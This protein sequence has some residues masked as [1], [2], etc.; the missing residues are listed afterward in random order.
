MK[1]RQ[2]MR[3]MLASDKSWLASKSW[4]TSRTS[5]TLWGT[6]GYHISYKSYSSSST[7]YSSA[8]SKLWNRTLHYT[9][10]TGCSDAVFYPM[11]V[12]FRG[13]RNQLKKLSFLDLYTPRG[14]EDSIEDY[15][16]VFNGSYKFISTTKY[17]H[18]ASKFA[19]SGGE[20]IVT[21]PPKI[22][23]NVTESIEKIKSQRQ[24]WIPEDP[25]KDWDITKECEISGVAPEG[26]KSVIDYSDVFMV[27]GVF[28]SVAGIPVYHGPI[29]VN[30]DYKPSRFTIQ[31]PSLNS[32]EFKL[33]QKVTKETLIDFK[34]A[35]QLKE[36]LEEMEKRYLKAREGF[37]T[38]SVVKITTMEQAEFILDNFELTFIDEETASKL[39]AEEKKLRKAGFTVHSFFSHGEKARTQVKDISELYSEFTP[40]V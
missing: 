8:S 29:Y 13:V 5:Y 38:T 39:I 2:S 19:R 18:I 6:M 31:I 7:S 16:V 24:A 4:T 35:N 17:D 23:I 30:K 11:S 3:A 9:N 20:V 36:R 14:E 15:A 28:A 33:I 10:I 27:R 21:N 32:A 26:K 40:M 12:V 37:P 1:S 34:T 22:S 25:E